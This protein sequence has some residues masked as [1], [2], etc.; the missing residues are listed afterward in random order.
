MDIKVEVCCYICEVSIINT[1][2]PCLILPRM[3]DVLRCF[4]ENEFVK[5][6]F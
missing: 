2:R 1:A 4:S 5:V 3:R 6:W